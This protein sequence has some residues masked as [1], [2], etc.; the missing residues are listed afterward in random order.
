MQERPL[1]HGADDM[2]RNPA[3]PAPVDT[4]GKGERKKTPDGNAPT[5]LINHVRQEAL[6]LIRI[7]LIPIALKVNSR[8]ELRDR[9][10]RPPQ[11]RRPLPRLLEPPSD[12]HLPEE[13]PHG[14]VAA[15]LQREVDAL[16][17][18]GVLALLEGDV[19]VVEGAAADAAG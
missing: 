5:Y 17:D 1:I 6:H 13:V 15:A 7:S 3:S 16:L 18:E 10:S 12:E 19:E 2:T 14:D 9:D 11:R 4:R 8:L